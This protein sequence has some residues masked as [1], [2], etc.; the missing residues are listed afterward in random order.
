MAYVGHFYFVCAVCNVT[1]GRHIHVSKP[2]FC[3]SFLTQSAYSFT[4]TPYFMC[5][6]T[7]YKLLSALR[8]RISEENTL[9]A[10]MQQII[11]AKHQAAC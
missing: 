2:T 10:T 9:N 5:H 11:T 6:C 4:R 7:W 8:V 3:R 1:S